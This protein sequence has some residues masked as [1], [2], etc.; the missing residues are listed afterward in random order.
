[1]A[2]LPVGG[3]EW[4]SEKGRKRKLENVGERNPH[5]H[6][7]VPSARGWGASFL[8]EQRAPQLVTFIPSSLDTEKGA[9]GS[10]YPK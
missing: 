7:F 3:D 5:R 8:T 2:S 9:V 10:L 4:V 6:L 1:M